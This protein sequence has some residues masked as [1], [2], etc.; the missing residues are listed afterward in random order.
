MGYVQSKFVR[1]LST[2]TVAGT[3]ASNVTAGSVLAGQ[4]WWSDTTVTISTLVSSQGDTVTQ[5]NTY[6]DSDSKRSCMFYVQ[7]ATAGATTI[8]LTLSASVSDI[9]ILYGEWSGLATSNVLDQHAVNGQAF[10]G[11]GTDLIT[12]GTVQT[13]A[14]GELIVGVTQN[15]FGSSESAGT[16]FTARLT[17]VLAMLEDRTQT[18]QG[19]IAA[20]ITPGANDAWHTGIM[21]FKPVTGGLFLPNP[22]NGL[23]G[24][25]PFF[26]NPLG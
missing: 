20:T 5:L 23:G 11:T 19:S 1:D 17:D 26:A 13:T 3:L 10:P 2:N 9:R 8:T 14:N 6:L 21:T 22:M 16:N 25:G 12:S 18:A 7:N 24:G 4:L 15:E